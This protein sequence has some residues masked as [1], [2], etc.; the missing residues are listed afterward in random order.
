[1]LIP[2]G[3]VYGDPNLIKN[4]SFDNNLNDW[5]TSGT[6][7]LD[8]YFGN[9]EPS[10]KLIGPSGSS[11]SAL[12]QNNIITSNKDLILSF[13]IYT[14][15]EEPVMSLWLQFWQ[16]HV[17]LS[18]PKGITPPKDKWYKFSM[19][20]SQIFQDVT[21]AQLPDFNKVDIKIQTHYETEAYIDNVSLAPP[22]IQS[23]T[24]TEP[25]QEPAPWIR[26]RQMTCY[27]VWI[28]EDNNFEF[29]FWWE[30][31]NNNW[32]K[33]YDMAGNEVFLIDMEKGNA[34]FEADLPDGM[35]TVKTFHDG[36]ETPIQEFVIGKP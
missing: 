31:A 33:I 10:V 24:I 30:Y 36:F 16:E 32:V 11:F 22:P 1:M 21:S 27:Q 34:R 20:L 17:A 23:F 13:D 14:S 18:I 9:P 4:G 28:N 2:S 35:Y 3:S 19:S 7:Y 26:D 12:F 29:V 25:I 5:G 8:P 6:V 15:S